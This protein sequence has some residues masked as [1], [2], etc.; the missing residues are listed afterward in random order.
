LLLI[1]RMRITG[2]NKMQDPL[3]PKRKESTNNTTQRENQQKRHPPD[4]RVFA[5]G[6]YIDRFANVRRLS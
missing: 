2:K 6:G 4:A 5:A 3:Q 1:T